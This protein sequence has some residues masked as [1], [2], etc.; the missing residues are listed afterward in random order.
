MANMKAGLG[1]TQ[2]LAESL[3]MIGSLLLQKTAQPALQ[4]K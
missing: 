4:P 2:E 3:G 1:R